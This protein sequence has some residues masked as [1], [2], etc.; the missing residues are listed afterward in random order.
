MI[1]WHLQS[2][3][4]ARLLRILKETAPVEHRRFLNWAASEGFSALHEIVAGERFERG[5]WFVPGMPPRFFEDPW[6]VLMLKDDGAIPVLAVYLDDV[7]ETW[8]FFANS[9]EQARSIEERWS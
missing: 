3:E 8:A 9:A 1:E 6:L 7:E 4:T 5:V 2:E